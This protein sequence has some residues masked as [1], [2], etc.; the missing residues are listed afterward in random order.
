MAKAL[1]NLIDAADHEA[2]RDIDYPKW[3][4]AGRV[5]DWRNYVPDLVRKAWDHLPV[6]T[7]LIVYCMAEQRASA[8]EWD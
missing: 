7:R 3:E 6:E 8:E 2:M 1:E 4:D 5:C